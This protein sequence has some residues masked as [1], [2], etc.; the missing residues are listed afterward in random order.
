MAALRAGRPGADIALAGRGGML[1]LTAGE[2]FAAFGAFGE[3]GRGGHGQTSKDIRNQRAQEPG[4][5]QKRS[6]TSPPL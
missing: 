5:V 3:E 2:A 1:H 4:A 6:S